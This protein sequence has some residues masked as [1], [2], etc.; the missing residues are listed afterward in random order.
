MSF[1][2]NP[3]KVISNTFHSLTTWWESTT[4][5]QQVDVAG[6]AALAEL[7]SLTPGALKNIAEATATAI[8]PVLAAGNPTAA[9][10]SAGIVAA[11][12][13]LKVEAK[14]VSATTL[15]T[16]VATIHNSVAA[17]VVV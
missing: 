16:F 7:E 17:Q 8:L 13:A 5:G 6:K 2:T 1:F 4:I 15:S 9:I 3:L 14:T 10:I 12:A 11:E